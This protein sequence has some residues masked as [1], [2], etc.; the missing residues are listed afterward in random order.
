MIFSEKYALMQDASAH[1]LFKLFP[2]HDNHQHDERLK[3]RFKEK[4]FEKNEDQE[5]DHEEE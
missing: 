5:P 2:H 4:Y 1:I 3:R